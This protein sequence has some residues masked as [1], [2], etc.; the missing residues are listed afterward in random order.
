MGFFCKSM[1]TIYWV[2]FN[3]F[4]HRLTKQKR[5]Q[6]AWEEGRKGNSAGQ[7]R[8]ERNPGSRSKITLTLLSAEKQYRIAPRQCLIKTFDGQPSVPSA[9]YK[10]PS[11]NLSDYLQAIKC[12]TG[13]I[14]I[15]FSLQ[16]F[17]ERKERKPKTLC[18]RLCSILLKRKRKTKDI[19]KKVS[20]P[21][22]FFSFS[23]SIY[24]FF[25][26]IHVGVSIDEHT[27][28]MTVNILYQ[29]S[30]SQVT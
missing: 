8:I 25:F 20:L 27:N 16:I 9:Y 3:V 26:Q 28:D 21:L 11:T 23:F 24:L 12:Q 7:D 5:F 18:I 6:A 19:F 13:K 14:E 29:L 1:N 10:I 4:N 15:A 17:H 22:F 30:E 2:N